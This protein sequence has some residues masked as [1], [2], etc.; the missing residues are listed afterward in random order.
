MDAAG[1]MEF[2][3][4]ACNVLAEQPYRKW[5]K[6]SLMVRINLH[7]PLP[8]RVLS[9]QR[10][11]RLFSRKRSATKTRLVAPMCSA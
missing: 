8:K 5:S 9:P 7:L 6:T 11:V 3:L 4:A 2:T 1:R 10:T